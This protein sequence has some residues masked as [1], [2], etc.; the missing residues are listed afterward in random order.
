MRF[1]TRKRHQPPAIIIVSLIDILIVLLIFMMVTMTFRQRPAVKL[2]LPES[3]Q[4]RRG[5][6][7][8]GVVVTVRQTEPRYYFKTRPVTL[9]RLQESLVLEAKAQPKLKL[10]I[11]AEAKAD[12]EHVLA[13]MDAAKA[14]KIESFGISVRNN[15]AP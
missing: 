9:E 1:S 14:A 8:D 13:A 11:D 5:V 6:T 4:A 7:E 15:P 2:A 12:W 10:T 3:R